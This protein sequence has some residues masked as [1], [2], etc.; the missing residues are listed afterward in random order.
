MVVATPVVT[1][2][3]SPINPGNSQTIG[4]SNGSNTQTL[5]FNTGLGVFQVANVI[6]SIAATSDNSSNID[7]SPVLT[8]TNS[9]KADASVTYSYHF[10][11]TQVPEPR[12]YGA[13]GAV[14]CLGLLGYRRL[15]ARQAAQ[16]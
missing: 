4:P 5:S 6:F 8:F 12:V 11:E 13:I 2:L 3:F 16:A 1:S 14:A 15:R 9:A 7:G 10:A